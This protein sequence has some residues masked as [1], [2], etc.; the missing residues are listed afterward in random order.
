MWSHTNPN[1]YKPTQKKK[2]QDKTDQRTQDKT[3]QLGG[4]GEGGQRRHK[5]RKDTDTD[6]TKTKKEVVRFVNQN[7]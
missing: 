5:L 6:N 4:W 2:S 1:P 3:S 7:D